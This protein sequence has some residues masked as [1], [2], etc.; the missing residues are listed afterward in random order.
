LQ[1]ALAGEITQRTHNEDALQTAIKT[2]EFLFGN[3]SLEFLQSLNHEEVLDVFEGIPQFPVSK[4]ELSAGIIVADLLAE[5]TKVFPSKGEAR[6]MI[7]GGGVAINKE[8]VADAAQ[9]VTSEDLLNGK[10]LVAQ[11]GKKNYFLL[12]AE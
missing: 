4:D 3:G 2:S 8:K 1:K 12:I 11:K 10:Y 7:Q 6:K 9:T 5:K